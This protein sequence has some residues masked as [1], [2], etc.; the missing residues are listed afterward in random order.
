MQ[1][2]AP[3]RDFGVWN[4]KT[5]ED[6]P[7]SDKL[8]RF[9]QNVVDLVQWKDFSSMLVPLMSGADLDEGVVYQRL[10]A[11]LGRTVGMVCIPNPGGNQKLKEVRLYFKF[12]VGTGFKGWT[13]YDYPNTPAFPAPR[14]YQVLN[15]HL[16]SLTGYIFLCPH[17][18]YNTNSSK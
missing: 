2:E 17:L 7:I 11:F 8:G 12:Q 18:S 6:A 13:L 15:P 14:C 9:F 1:K 16:S 10:S 5:T 4:G 3:T